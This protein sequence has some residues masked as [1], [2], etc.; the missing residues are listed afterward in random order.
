MDVVVFFCDTPFRWRFSIGFGMDFWVNGMFDCHFALS[1]S[2][3][4]VAGNEF[5]LLE[6]RIPYDASPII[7]GNACNSIEN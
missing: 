4:P 3:Y 6:D 2:D 7:E 1:L 5:V